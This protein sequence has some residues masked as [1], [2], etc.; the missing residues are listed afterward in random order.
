MN[1][2]VVAAHPDDEVLGAGGTIARHAQNGDRVTIAILGEGIT[3][4]RLSRERA[5]EKLLQSL[6][7]D[8]RRAAKLVGCEDLRL[9]QLP[10]NRFDHVDHLDVVKVVEEVVDTTKPQIVYTHHHGDLNTDH[11][12]TARAVLTACRPLPGTQVR[13]ILAFEVPSSTGWGFPEHAFSPTVF[14]DISCTLDAK[15]EAM[16]AYCSE[17]RDHPHPR[18]PQA[19]ADRARA[20]GSQVG[21]PAAE[22]FVLLRELIF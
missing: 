19:L 5:D 9:F 13:R 12:I 22:P 6:G 7:A 21:V 3:S 16:K 2:L 8:A 10:D 20:W 4:R 15:V 11:V 17:V 18:S 14:V 1:I